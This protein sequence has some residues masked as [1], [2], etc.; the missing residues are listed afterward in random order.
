MENFV[1]R[2]HLYDLLDRKELKKIKKTLSEL[3]PAD[4]TLIINDSPSEY[5]LP[6]FLSLS[7]QTASDVLLELHSEVKENITNNL[8][9]TKLLGIIDQMD[10]DEQ[11]DLIAELDED[12]KNEILNN[13]LDKEDKKIIKEFLTYNEDSAGGLMK[14]EVISVN[15]KFTVSQVIEFIGKNYEEVENL[16]YIFVV[17]DKNH[18]IGHVNLAKLIVAKKSRSVGE[19]VEK[20]N[21]SA[22]VNM[23]QEKVAHIFRKYDIYSLPVVDDNGILR[24][25]IT[26]DDII[27]VIDEEASEDVYKMVG[28]ENED[29]VFTSPFNSVRKRLPWLSL[30]LLTAFLVSSIVGIFEQTISQ[31]SYLAVLMPIV[32]GL[33]GNSGTQTLTVIVRGIALGD[34]T[35]HNTYKAIVKEL[36]VG[37]INGFIIGSFA[38]IVAF[39]FKKNIMLG[40]VLGIA[41]ISNMFIASVVG[42]IIPVIIK[43]LKF[44][45]ALASSILITMLTDMGG[46]VSFLGLATIFVV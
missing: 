38:M 23:D 33:G 45:P 29:K 5:Q 46:F 31:L 36:T 44:D 9:R 3:H 35:I 8:A 27:D 21:F 14:S 15:Q 10:S 1:N 30:N 13:I 42:S 32:A 11:V 22:H 40:V 19:I 16:Y 37:I 18:L 7:T 41:M 12:K 26:V 39:L 25:R 43:K 34:L 17:D 4:I 2:E 6:I 28:L 24:G 20:D